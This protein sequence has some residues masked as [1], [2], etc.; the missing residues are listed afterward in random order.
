MWEFVI[1]EDWLSVTEICWKV[2]WLSILMDLLAQHSSFV[3]SVESG[4]CSNSDCPNSDCSNSD[5]SNS[6]CSNSD[7]SNS[8]CSNSDCSNYNF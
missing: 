6:D 4:T 2:H 7:C 3:I 1:N 8:D 5:C